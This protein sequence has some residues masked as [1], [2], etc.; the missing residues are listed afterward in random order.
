MNVFDGL[1]VMS[2]VHSINITFEKGSR[3]TGK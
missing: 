3:K 1:T 2:W